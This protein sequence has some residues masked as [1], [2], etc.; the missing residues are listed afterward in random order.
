MD[1]VTS[2]CVD[3]AHEPASFYPQLRDVSADKR[4]RVYWQCTVVFFSTSV[5][6][7]PDARHLLYTN[8]AAPA[9]WDGV[10][11]REF[12]SSIGVEIRQLSFQTFCPPQRFSKEFRN[13]FYKLDVLQE[14][15]KPTAAD[16]SLLL[17]SD[18]V[19]TRPDPKLISLVQSDALLLLD[20]EPESTPDTKIHG[21]SRRDMGNLYREL[22]PNYPVEAPLHF[23]GEII[24]G[25]RARLGEVVEQ[26]RAIQDQVL[27]E[28]PAGPPRFSSGR[29]LFDGDEYLTSFVCNRLPRPW[30]DTSPFIRR[31]WTSY[32]NT[33]VRRSDVQLTI[34][35]L[36]NEKMQ[37]LPV[38]C[39]QML[40]RDSAFWRLAPTNLAGYLGRY[41]G[42]PNP[43][44][45]PQ[46]LLTLANKL[47]RLV[48]IAKRM[49]TR[50]ATTV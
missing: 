2:L 19:W 46:R 37:G 36:P 32:R 11:H 28:Y 44:W 15:A 14:L 7:N 40:R 20:A 30:T 10:D 1:I 45:S 23:G 34:W 16:H 50:P 4:R 8:D 31:I 18:C 47:P 41:L 5:R 9:T 26:L 33:N 42:V 21:L 24:G 27:V 39:R 49:L 22:D 38:L 3:E 17:D 12:L 6:C 29:T 35:H 25:S 13:A 43:V 48:V